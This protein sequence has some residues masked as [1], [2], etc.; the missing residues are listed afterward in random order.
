LP[1]GV[2]LIGAAGADATL[3]GLGIALQREL[4]VPPLAP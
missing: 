3:L 2:S 4:G 1:T